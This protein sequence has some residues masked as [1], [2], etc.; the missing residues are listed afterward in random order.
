MRIRVRD[1][2]WNWRELDAEAVAVTWD[3]KQSQVSIEAGTFSHCQE[4]TLEEH[5]VNQVGRSISKGTLE[6]I[7]QEEQEAQKEYLLWKKAG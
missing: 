5:P 2:D 3:A 7:R 1:R 4:L 6:R